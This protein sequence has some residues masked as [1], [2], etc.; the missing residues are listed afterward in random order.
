MKLYS[1]II[2]K[3]LKVIPIWK[4]KYWLI[5]ILNRKQVHVSGCLRTMPNLTL[6]IIIMTPTSPI[7]KANSKMFFSST[8]SKQSSNKALYIKI[9]IP[10]FRNRHI[11]S[12][13]QSRVFRHIS[14]RRKYPI[15]SKNSTAC[16]WLVKNHS[17]Q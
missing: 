15:N 14:L 4:S 5:S 6:P 11:D 3:V 8:T 17:I 7:G 1:T 16:N 10:I 9:I 2:M 12:L 13:S